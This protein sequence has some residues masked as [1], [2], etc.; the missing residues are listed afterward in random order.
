MST[1][2]NKIGLAICLSLCDLVKKKFGLSDNHKV[3]KMC[4]NQCFQ[5]FPL[6]QEEI[7]KIINNAKTK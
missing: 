4:Y 3:M 1:E 5:E 7:L 6:P 2:D